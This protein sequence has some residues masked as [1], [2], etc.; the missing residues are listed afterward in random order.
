MKD[1]RG[2]RMCGICA[3]K[4]IDDMWK[5]VVVIP[6]T[7]DL[8]KNLA[9]VHGES[10][11]NELVFHTDDSSANRDGLQL[12]EA[13]GDVM[14]R[15]EVEIFWYFKPVIGESCHGTDQTP[16]EQHDFIAGGLQFFALSAQGLRREGKEGS[17]R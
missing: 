8:R 7:L 17:T 4:D 15:T 9:E 3:S 6:R 5:M 2:N 10:N 11:N 14:N 13:A 16:A 1:R 12:I